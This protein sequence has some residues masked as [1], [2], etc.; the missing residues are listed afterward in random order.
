[1]E[2]TH[3]LCVCV[4]VGEG[5]GKS[6]ETFLFLFSGLLVCAL[7]K[8]ATICILV[9]KSVNLTDSFLRIFVDQH[10]TSLAE[11]FYVRKAVQKLE[12]Q[13]VKKTGRGKGGKLRESV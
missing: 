1:M 10:S 2:K 7:E 8:S 5:G 4:G 6:R 12:S 11:I 13:I 3:S 9:P